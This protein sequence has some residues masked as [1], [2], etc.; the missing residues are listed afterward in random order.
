MNN[1]QL[2]QFLRLIQSGYKENVPYHNAI[3]AADVTQTLC[4][5]YVKCGLNDLTSSMLRFASFI[6]AV[7]HDVV[8]VIT[9][10]IPATI[11]LR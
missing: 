6:A 4:H 2:K 8:S 3:H 11:M 10:Y 1:E 9:P 5:F 7:V